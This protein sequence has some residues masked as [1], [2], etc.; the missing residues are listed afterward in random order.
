M[1]S[2]IFN[3][4]RMITFTHACRNTNTLINAHIHR[5]I[6]THPCRIHNVHI[7]VRTFTCMQT[8]KHSSYTR[9]N[10]HTHTH[11]HTHTHK[12]TDTHIHS[13]KHI[14]I[15]EHIQSSFLPSFI[16]SFIRYTV[17]RLLKTNNGRT[18][19]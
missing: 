15:H 8:Y 5:L 7:H 19:Q 16:H 14:Y 11:T 17:Y 12:R 9:T 18:L 1:I 3:V 2:N 4:K 6:L 10:K 13:H